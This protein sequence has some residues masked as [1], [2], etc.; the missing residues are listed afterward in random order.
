MQLDLI[1]LRV[2]P[3]VRNAGSFSYHLISYT[4]LQIFAD[5]FQNFSEIFRIF[6]QPKPRKT[7][8]V[9]Y[10]LVGYEHLERWRALITTNYV[11]S[12]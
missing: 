5:F 7:D 1:A 10:A 6:S 12:T 2:P 11:T 4:I 3:P 9:G 8:R